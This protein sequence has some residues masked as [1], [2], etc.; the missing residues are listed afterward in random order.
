VDGWPLT[1]EELEET[2]L[3]LVASSPDP[4]EPPSG[5][6]TV[7]AVFVAFSTS[8]DPAPR[9]RAWAAA[10]AG[11]SRAVIAGEVEVAY[12][13]GYLALREG[14]LLERAVRGLDAV[15]DVLLVNASGRDH[16]R[17]AGLALHLGAV[18]GV[19]T[20]GVTDRPLVAHLDAGGWLMLD[21][22]VVGRAVSTGARPVIAHAAWRT[23][24]WCAEAVVRAAAG[25]ARTPEPL[26][27]ARFLARS[28]RARDEGRLPVGWSMDR[29]D[30]PR[31][32]VGPERGRH[33]TMAR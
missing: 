21:G 8:R 23:D 29:L 24:A 30:A 12:E 2:Q 25:R 16:P 7:G 14:P 26:R 10:V 17:R 22:R 15:P 1:R 31:F 3:R 33:G 20:V 32:P 19:P 5:P 4:W 6:Y 11:S 13:P 18:L 9:E 28:R 27:L